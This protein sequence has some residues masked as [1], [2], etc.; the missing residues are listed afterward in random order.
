[1]S[2]LSSGTVTFLFTDI[3]GSTQL[4]QRL[5]EQYAS[6]LRTHHQIITDAITNHH[7]QVVDTQG[8]SFFAVFPRAI[9]ALHAVVEAQRT[10]TSY[11]WQEGTPVRVRMALH[12]GE[13]LK[14]AGRYVGIDVHRA[15]RIGSAGHGSQILLSQTTKALVEHQLPEDVTLRDLGG[16]YL[17]DL[18]GP[19]PIFQLVI[20]GLT[21]DF[22]PLKT[23]EVLPNNLPVQ[24]TSFIG[25]ETQLAEIKHL[26]GTTHLLTLTGVGG[27]GKTRL[28]HKMGSDVIEDFKDGVW[29]VELAPLSNPE[30]VP[31]AIAAA[32]NLREQ[33]GQSLTDLLKDYLSRKK[34]LLIL[35]NCEHL[36][37][38]CAQ[39]ASVLLHAAPS[40]KILATSREALGIGG[41]APYPVPSLSLPAP[42]AVLP[43]ALLQYEAVQLFV[44]RA[45]A[46]DLHFQLTH[47]NGSAVG[48]IC[49]RLDGIPLALEL[50]AARVKGL[51]VEQI[52]ARLDDRFRLL[53]GGSRTA[54]PRQRTL[55]AAIDWSYRLLMLPEQ[56][57]LRR[58]SVFARGWTL[59]AAE[60]VCSLGLASGDVLEILLRLVDKSLVVAETERTESRY[61][62]LETI[63]QY[64]QEKL[65]E[66]GE[67]VELRQHHLQYFRKLA[68][69]AELR[70]RSADQLEWMDQVD[71]EQDNI[72]AALTWAGEGDSVEAGLEL[73]TS[74]WVFWV[75]RGHMREGLTF[76]E[77]LL[78]L[79]ETTSALPTRAKAH[80]AAGILAHNLG[81]TFASRGHFEQSV[82]LW[83]RLGAVGTDGLFDVEHWIVA[84]DPEVERDSSL[85]GH[86]YQD[87]LKHYRQIADQSGIAD[88]LQTV[89]LLAARQGNLV[90]ARQAFEESLAIFQATG[91]QI[92]LHHLKSDLAFVEFEEGNL[93]QALTLT[94]DTIHF[95]RRAR[96][97]FVLGW[98]LCLR[99]AIAIRECDYVSAK[100]LYSEGLQVVQQVDDH[101]QVP[102]CFIG[103]AGIASAD[104]SF[105]HAARLLGAA[106]AKLAERN[107]P[108]EH[109]DQVELERLAKFLSVELGETAFAKARAEGG[110]LTTEQAIALALSQ[111]E[112]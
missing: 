83:K 112:S 94:E 98:V 54:L 104:R 37:D 13:P 111:S 101:T 40:L 16:H 29:L 72:R 102:E 55:Q 81:A 67:G 36:I 9:D 52:A 8:D 23:L 19:Q 39:M 86:Y 10:L 100:A 4:L 96:F 85:A 3:E 53:T 34:L 60:F 51:S 5:K 17:K 73:A 30:L 7:G 32:L 18:P 35:D 68:K 6:L 42:A 46:V 38:A 33:P 109:F 76:L 15:A 59:E 92:R 95:F 57:V 49:Q 50:A 65:D 11:D 87:R 82:M 110:A 75:Y 22:P 105:E 56:L 25:R 27:T 78:G 99:G 1:M 64:A 43:D 61:H 24:L 66:T 47:K 88:T 26:F 63:R 70:L 45:R 103:F 28:A 97:T 77:R 93:A 89:G 2:E 79:S 12:T 62:M 31:Q 71:V 20:S 108:L 69:N 107:M 84:F 14:D 41:E 90:E 80:M 74:L 91:D 106:E 44:D 58:V 21:N 48:Q